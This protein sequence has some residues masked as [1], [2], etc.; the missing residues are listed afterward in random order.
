ML[1]SKKED[2]WKEIRKIL[3]QTE[4]IKDDIY[5]V[6]VANIKSK[7]TLAQDYSMHSVTTEFLSE[8]E[9]EEIIQAFREFG[10]YSHLF[11]EEDKFFDWVLS[12]KIDQ[13]IRTKKLVY[14]SA[15]AGVGPGRKSLIPA[16]CAL[17]H[18]PITGSDSYVVSLARQKYHVNNIIR[19]LGL[20]APRSWLYDFKNHWL[21]GKQPANGEKVIVKLTYESASI[22][23]DKNSVMI[24]DNKIEDY[25]EELS[26]KFLQPLTV[27]EFISG[28]EVEVPVFDLDTPFAP[29]V[30]GISLN[31]K[32]YLQD[33]ILTY[34]DVYND[35]YSFYKVEQFSKEQA[36]LI[37]DCAVK[38]FQCLG[39]RGLGRVDFRVKE[40]G[41]FYVMDVATNPHIIK[42]SSFAFLYEGEGLAYKYLPSTLVGLAC[43]RISWF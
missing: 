41:N 39:I 18:I 26:K 20:T 36:S 33:N 37:S 9:T 11:I 34:D 13:A 30:V 5:L 19:N 21:L 14:N 32:Q 1:S 8:S 27:Q 7:T 28:Y 43:K 24:I 6:V 12:H 40:N 3:E 31:D 10:F 17:H 42:H 29:M 2:G 15:Q 25:L 22:G 38:V 16:F 23:L 35:S 4:Q